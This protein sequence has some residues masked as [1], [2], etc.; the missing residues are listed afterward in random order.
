[1]AQVILIAYLIDEIGQGDGKAIT[2]K[3]AATI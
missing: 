1:M 2:L 3:D